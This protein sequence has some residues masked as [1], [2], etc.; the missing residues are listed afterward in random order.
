MLTFLSIRGGFCAVDALVLLGADRAF[1]TL[2]IEG[3]HR[4]LLSGA[5]LLCM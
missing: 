3:L 2:R 5:V 1:C 4:L